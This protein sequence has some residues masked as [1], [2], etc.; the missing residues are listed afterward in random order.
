VGVAIRMY[1]TAT[2]V[3]IPKHHHVKP[4]RAFHKRLFRD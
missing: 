2:V 3:Q 4:L 1:V